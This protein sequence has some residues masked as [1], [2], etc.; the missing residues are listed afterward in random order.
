MSYRITDYASVVAVA[1]SAQTPE[2]LDSDF[3][4]P[5]VTQVV[6]PWA[7]THYLWDIPYHQA[8]RYAP[9]ITSSDGMLFQWGL[10]IGQNVKSP[11]QRFELFKRS[12]WAV[13]YAYNGMP[14]KA[15]AVL[16]YL[17]RALCFSDRAA[18]LIQASYPLTTQYS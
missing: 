13:M 17:Q 4:Q 9:F 8:V 18:E 1:V 3:F 12:V 11:E 5:F 14:P 6:G 15:A 16:I 10:F 2:G 7:M